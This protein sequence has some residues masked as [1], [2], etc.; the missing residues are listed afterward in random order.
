VCNVPG[1]STASTAQHAI[2]LLLE[3][4]NRVGIHA[5]DVAQGGWENSPVFS[6]YLEPLLELDG[7]TL[8]IVGYGAIG[9]RVARIARALGMRVIVHTRSPSDDWEVRFVNKAT[10]LAES[11]AISLHVP[12][13]SET[14]HYLDANAFAAMKRTALVVNCSRGPVIDEEALLIALTK[15]TIRGAG[16]DV[17]GAEPPAPGHP[18]LRLPNCVV[19]PHIAWASMAARS[20]LLSITADNIEAF[21]QGR[22]QNVVGS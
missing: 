4:A 14:H 8:G 22:P 19:T 15:G 6:Y 20:R 9:R 3:L 11:D 21:L 12:L 16:L 7:A 2:A 13:S 17:L 10:L 18:L 1:Y 5:T